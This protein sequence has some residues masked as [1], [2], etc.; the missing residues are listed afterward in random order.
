VG[1]AGA[2]TLQGG[3]GPDTLMSVGDATKD[4]SACG[5]ETDVAKADQIDSVAADCETV[6]KT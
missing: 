2:D 1:H 6:N 4:S 3:A 5:S